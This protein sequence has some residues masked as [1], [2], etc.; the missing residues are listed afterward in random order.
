MRV[1][2]GGGV[3]MAR[4]NNNRASEQ[5][6]RVG[7]CLEKLKRVVFLAKPQVLGEIWKKIKSL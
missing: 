4:Y 2:G 3:E 1:I 7:V 5:M 6:E